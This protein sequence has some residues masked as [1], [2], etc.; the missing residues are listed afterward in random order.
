MK[1][2]MTV[3]SG[4]GIDSSETI[5][6]GSNKRVS[7]GTLFIVAAPSGVRTPNAGEYRNEKRQPV[8]L[9]F[10][11][12]FLQTVQFLFALLQTFCNCR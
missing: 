11:K 3:L 12:L 7:I 6:S 1:C 2:Y 4:F 9:F 10:L 8:G 5:L